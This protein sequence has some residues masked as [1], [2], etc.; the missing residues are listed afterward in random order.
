MRIAISPVPLPYAPGT[1]VF[2]NAIQVRPSTPGPS[3]LKRTSSAK[4][5]NA[6]MNVSTMVVRLVVRC[7]FSS[8][9]GGTGN[10]DGGRLERT[11]PAGT[12]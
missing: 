9:A 5:Q 8:R 7:H 4:N 11:S 2:T 12:A 6:C 3:A 1:N 10:H